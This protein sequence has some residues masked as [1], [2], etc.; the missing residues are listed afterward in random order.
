MANAFA[1][2]RPPGHHAEPKAS[3]GY[4]IYNNVAIGA[5]YAQRTLKL[6]RVLIVDWDLHHGNGTQDCFANDPSVLFFSTHQRFIYPHTG[7]L[8]EVGKGRGRGY[9]I[10]VPL[11]P[12]FGDGD[13][14]H[15]FEALLRPVALA[16]APDL[17]LVSAGFDIHAGDPLGGMCVTPQGFAALTRLLMKISEECCQGRLVMSLEGGYDLAALAQSVRAVLRELSGLEHTDRVP[18]LATAE[19]QKCA[20]VIWRV[21]RRHGRHWPCL[22]SAPGDQSDRPPSWAKRCRSRLARARVYFS[23]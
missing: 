15:L 8:R 22:L 21:R 16:F 7:R 14:L 13:F 5:R 17:I 23:T 6:S 1:L 19:R 11:L 2:V 9:T 10:N 18:I 3:G 12:G 20:A 4:C